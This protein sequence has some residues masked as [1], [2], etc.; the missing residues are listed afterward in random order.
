M[1]GADVMPGIASRR[2]SCYER[3]HGS[4]RT[5]EIDPAHFRRVM[6]RF[7]SGVTVI[8]AGEP[9]QVRGMTA[10]AFMSG[11]LEPPLCVVSIAKRAHMHAAADR[12]PA[13]SA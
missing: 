4:A 13:R 7:A 2:A 10:T 5:A 8:T 9:G 3:G 1:R 12:R 11:S 6:S